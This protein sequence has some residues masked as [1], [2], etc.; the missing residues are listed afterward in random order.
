MLNHDRKRR[1]LLW[2]FAIT[3]VAAFYFATQFAT[4]RIVA[5]DGHFHIRYSQKMLER[6]IP[7]KLPELRYTIYNDSFRDDHLLFHI[8]NIPFSLIPDMRVGA[9]LSAALF[10]TAAALVFF[11][12]IMSLRVKLPLAW[13]ALF[14]AGSEVLLFRIQMPRV[15]SLALALLL[16]AIFALIKRRNVMLLVVCALNVWLYDSFFL[17]VVVGITWSVSTKLVTG[18]FELKPLAWMLGGIALATVVNPDFPRNYASYYFNMV[19]S[20]APHGSIP[21]PAEWHPELGWNML[22]DNL[23][24]VMAAVA[25]AVASK[26]AHRSSDV[27]NVQTR[28]E[29]MYLMLLSFIFIALLFFAR[30]FVEYTPAIVLVYLA[31]IHRDMAEGVPAD[32][33]PALTAVIAVCALAGGAVGVVKYMK[34]VRTDKWY[35]CYMD[36]GEWIDRNVAPGETVFSSDWDDFPMLYMQAPNVRYVVGL[37][38]LFMLR[39][40]EGLYD[41][42]RAITTGKY[43]GS[44]S[45]AIMKFFDSRY[46]FTDEQHGD[47]ISKIEPDP[48]VQMVF[49]GDECRVYRIGN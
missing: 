7:D 25:L 11:F 5:N 35:H 28:T 1:L 8:L 38:P 23:P 27:L 14:A 31:V 44:H 42:Y 21:Q 39:Y 46:I 26:L 24:I 47:F 33:K 36:A 6:G 30:R 49:K 2:V 9:K 34:D 12:V 13:L 10:A 29:Q 43:R 4:Y 22:V 32:W 18:R 40:D 3:S 45:D 41:K 19:R 15:Q 48:D 17:L 20:V 37:D 16:L